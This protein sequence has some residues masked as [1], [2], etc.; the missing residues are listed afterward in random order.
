[1]RSSCR[2]RLSQAFE[3]ENLSHSN[4][5]SC[6]KFNTSYNNIIRL[7]HEN[8]TAVAIFLSDNCDTFYELSP[9][10]H[11]RQLANEN[12]Y[13]TLHFYSTTYLPSSR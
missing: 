5:A 13:L 3:S 7:G 4:S 10:K 2:F 12:V 8:V 9:I 6:L 1:M 11:R